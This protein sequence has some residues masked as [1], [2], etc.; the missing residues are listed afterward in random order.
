VY[1][2]AGTGSSKLTCDLTRMNR[3]IYTLCRRHVFFVNDADIAKS[4]ASN[5][6]QEIA[7]IV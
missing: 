3:K 6:E 1:N 7:A 4:T 5:S 2:E